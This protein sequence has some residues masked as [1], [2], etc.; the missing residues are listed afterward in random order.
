M[1]DSKPIARKKNT[2]F[3]FL[4]LFIGSC[5][6]Q[7]PAFTVSLFYYARSG[8]A[9]HLKGERGS[10]GLRNVLR[11]TRACVS[12]STSRSGPLGHKLSRYPSRSRPAGLDQY[13][14]KKCVYVA[15]HLGLPAVYISS[16]ETYRAPNGVTFECGYLLFWMPIFRRRWIGSWLN[17]RGPPRTIQKRTSS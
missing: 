4:G 9:S 7:C 1:R 3:L 16:K 8:G 6:G 10:W 5:L 12:N 2:V 15:F 11:E 13:L 14:T 17:R